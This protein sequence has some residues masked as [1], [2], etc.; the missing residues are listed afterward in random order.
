LAQASLAQG[1]CRAVSMVRSCAIV[2]L[3]LVYAAVALLH[4]RHTGCWCGASPSTAK[5][6]WSLS[7]MPRQGEPTRR[8]P[9]PRLQRRSEIITSALLTT[10]LLWSH[11]GKPASAKAKPVVAQDKRFQEVLV[12]KWAQ[13]SKGQPDLVLGLRGDAYVL[14]PGQDGGALR[15]Y[16]LKAECTH[17]GCLVQWDPRGK[18]FLCPC[19]GSQYDSEGSVLRGPAPHPLA[20][21]Q[22]GL[23][24][25]GKVQLSAWEGEDFRDGSNP[26]WAV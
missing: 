11:G 22:V 4:E 18:K 16:A 24:A 3:L 6:R 13:T 9:R 1:H 19:H 17:L 14:L 10:T 7:S 21:A 26:W 15:N 20:L 5:P 8:D 25:E 23:T 12:S 2:V